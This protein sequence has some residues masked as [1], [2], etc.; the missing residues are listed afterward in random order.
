MCHLC[1]ICSAGKN[2]VRGVSKSTAARSLASKVERA[3]KVMRAND[4]QASKDGR[5]VAFLRA[6]IP[7]TGYRVTYSIAER[8]PKGTTVHLYADIP[9]DGSARGDVWI[10]EILDHTL[11][12]PSSRSPAV[13]WSPYWQRKAEEHVD[14]D[15]DLPVVEDMH[16][17][18]A[19]WST[20]PKATEM[21]MYLIQ[22]LRCTSRA[23][24]TA[25]LAAEPPIWFDLS[26]MD[27][28]VGTKSTNAWEPLPPQ[29]GRYSQTRASKKAEA[30]V[31]MQSEV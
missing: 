8:L 14:I 5:V 15:A 31:L 29:Y 26:E 23:V 9:Q 21:T 22:W 17:I 13:K 6:M 30:F 7:P 11:T 3:R 1:R 10:G 25:S 18:A 2:S 16:E 24:S 27:I 20:R 4:R 19:F 28:D 12:L